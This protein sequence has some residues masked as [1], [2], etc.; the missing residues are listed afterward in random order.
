MVIVRQQ[1]INTFKFP[2]CPNKELFY[3]TGR[4]SGVEWT[5]T[6]QCVISIFQCLGAARR[7]TLHRDFIF[8]GFFGVD[9]VRII[10]F[11]A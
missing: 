5:D 11:V 7:V 10:Y 1:H 3:V 4:E 9:E 2:V 6:D 8:T